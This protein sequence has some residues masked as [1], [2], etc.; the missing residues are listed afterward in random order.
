MKCGRLLGAA[1]TAFFVVAGLLNTASPASAQTVVYVDQTATG[2]G[3][4]TSWANAFVDLQDGI[5]AAD[6]G[7]GPSDPFLE[8]SA[9]WSSTQ[10][11]T[12]SCVFLAVCSW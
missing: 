1:L 10:R 11:R 5:D 4:G 8:R 9:S 6:A 3:N 7:E 12:P 2:A